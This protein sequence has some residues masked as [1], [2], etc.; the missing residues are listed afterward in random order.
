MH[1]TLNQFSFPV[2]LSTL[3]L[4]RHRQC[5]T[6]FSGNI[7]SWELFFFHPCSAVTKSQFQNHLEA[8]AT[9]SV[10]KVVFNVVV[11]KTLGRSCPNA[12]STQSGQESFCFGK[13]LFSICCINERN[14]FFL[15]LCR[16]LS[17]EINNQKKTIKKSRFIVGKCDK[18][19]RIA[20]HSEVLTFQ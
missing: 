19:I 20:E 9:S 8:T 11:I 17:A 5:Y 15:F 16:S 18:S 13:F 4:R 3:W 10:V 1:G 6:T 2:F 7:T 14:V 12:H